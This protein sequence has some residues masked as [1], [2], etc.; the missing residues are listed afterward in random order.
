MII[1]SAYAVGNTNVASTHST[2][3]TSLSHSGYFNTQRGTLTY[4]GGDGVMRYS[5]G[6]FEKNHQ[7]IHW[8]LEIGTGI[9]HT[10]PINNLI[11]FLLYFW[12]LE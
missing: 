4:Y 12:T 1:C 7:W 2:P 11:G 6:L 5:A 8:H 3:R 9:K 10:E